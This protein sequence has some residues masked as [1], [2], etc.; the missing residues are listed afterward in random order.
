MMQIYEYLLSKS[1]PKTESQIDVVYKLF[2]QYSRHQLIK[3]QKQE[4]A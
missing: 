2:E 4:T 3:Y 1:K